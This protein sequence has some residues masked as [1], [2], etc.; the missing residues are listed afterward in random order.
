MSFASTNAL[1]QM[2]QRYYAGGRSLSA[3][4]LKELFTSLTAQARS[5]HG[6]YA[7]EIQQ[8]ASTL[9]PAQLLNLVRRNPGGDL[10]A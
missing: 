5:L 7:G 6:R 8:R 2:A 4:Q 9:N 3:L 1:G 10:Q